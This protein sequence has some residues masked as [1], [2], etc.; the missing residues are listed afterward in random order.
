V[1]ADGFASEIVLSFSRSKLKVSR[2]WNSIIR[3]NGGDRF[4]RVYQLRSVVEK[5]AQNQSYHNWSITTAGYPTEEVYHQAESLYNVI[6]EGRA[7]VDYS[8]VMGS[9]ASDEI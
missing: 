3:M 5:N 1:A 4:S 2:K 7:A 8:D 9:E 6:G